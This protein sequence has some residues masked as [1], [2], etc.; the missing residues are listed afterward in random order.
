LINYFGTGI[1][2]RMCRIPNVEESQFEIVTASFEKKTL[3]L[4]S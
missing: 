4:N 2:T 3:D 1:F